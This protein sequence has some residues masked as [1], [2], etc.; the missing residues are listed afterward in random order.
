M[1]LLEGKKALI[2]G[3]ANHRSIAWAIAQALASEGAQL[4]LTYQDRMEKYVRD[5]AKKIP[6]TEVIACDVQQDDQLDSAFARTGEIFEGGLDILIHSVAYAPPSELENPFVQTTREG[7]HTALDISAYSLVAMARRA[8]PLMQARGGGSMLALT[9]MA[10][11]RVMP[12]YNVMAV[13]KAALEC[14]VRYLAFE[15]GEHNIRVNAISAGPLNTLAARG[16][17][18]FTGFREH[19]GITSPLRRNIEQ[20]EV[21]DAALFLSSPYARAI[22][23]EIMF[24]DAGYNIMGA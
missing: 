14:S 21:G 22:T 11:E 8:A 3:V 15:L 17:S 9:Y 23:G 13:A 5:L 16:I 1:P 24:V 19:M 10:S 2:F 20:S 7:F 6:G 12:K 18:G 4:A